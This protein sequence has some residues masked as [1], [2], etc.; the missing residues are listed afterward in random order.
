MVITGFD[1]KAKP[2]EEL[3]LG[4]PLFSDYT[5]KVDLPKSSSG[6]MDFEVPGT[7]APES[8]AGG[9]DASPKE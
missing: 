5:T 1:G 9:G 8:A 7:G 4:M 3:P 6:T 2:D